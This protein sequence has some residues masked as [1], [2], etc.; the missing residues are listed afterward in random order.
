METLELLLDYRALTSMYLAV[1]SIQDYFFTKE[2]FDGLAPRDIDSDAVELISVSAT[3]QPGPGN[4][5]GQP[6]RRITPKGGTKRIFQ[7][8]R[9]FTEMELDGDALKALREPDSFGLQEKGRQVV[10]LQQEEQAIRH[11]L[12][13]EVCLAN[14]LTTGRVEF[15]ANGNILTP[16]VNSS[17]GAITS[18]TGAAVAADFGVDNSHRGALT[19]SGTS[20]ITALWSTAGTV[21]S[22]Q[23]DNLVRRAGTL[24]VPR[25]KHIYVN[26]VKK[27][28]LRANTEFN[29]W[30]KY[31]SRR[32]DEVLIGDGIDG[33][34]GFNWHFVDGTWTDA[35]GT[36]RD[37]IPQTSAII[38]PE[39]GAWLR[40][41]RVSE[42]VPR[43][44]MLAQTPTELLNQLEKVY[45]EFSYACL[46]HNPVK[47]LAYYGDN[48][49][50]NYADPNAIWQP[51]VFA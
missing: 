51:T 21:I 48:F 34:W 4:L 44:M 5:R 32:V 50:L 6:A 38:M 20:I 42:L 40:A 1:P 14:I 13:K 49:A 25:P 17:T 12:F 23:L 45:G 28:L 39:K 27:S 9:Y 29:D 36:T 47:L 19:L 2:F 16:S 35:S 10:E 15:D 8:F 31:N 33:L 3:T 11:R 7:A 30:A 46:S 41:H 18:A 26:A 24:G 37:L 43:D 22:L